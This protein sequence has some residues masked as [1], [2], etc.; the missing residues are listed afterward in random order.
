MIYYDYNTIITDC[1]HV[2]MLFC[3]CARL[4]VETGLD[5]ICTACS[6]VFFSRPSGNQF[7][8][9][10]LN[11]WHVSVWGIKTPQHPKTTSIY[12]ILA[13]NQLDLYPCIV[14]LIRIL[15]AIF[16]GDVFFFFFQPP[17][18]MF[19]PRLLGSGSSQV[20]Q[21]VRA[22]ASAA[23]RMKQMK[24]KVGLGISIAMVV[25]Q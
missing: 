24:L 13:G 20:D 18:W 4:A 11:I 10:Y 12:H 6:V 3:H 9:G 21:I 2:I 15:T 1:I 19:L 16:Q 23:E 5:S 22:E 14:M 25:P 8:G 17:S 7:C